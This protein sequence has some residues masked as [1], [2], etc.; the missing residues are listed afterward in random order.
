MWQQQASL[1]Q[2]I[3]QVQ[4]TPVSEMWPAVEAPHKSVVDMMR[5]VNLVHPKDGE[6]TI[7]GSPNPERL[8]DGVA[9]IGLKRNLFGFLKNPENGAPTILPADADPNL[10]ADPDN[11][12]DPHIDKN[13]NVMGQ[14][15]EQHNEAEAAKSRENLNVA[16]WVC[17]GGLAVV[18]YSYSSILQKVNA[19]H[20]LAS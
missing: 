1:W 11:I 14:Y 18:A 19:F 5:E 10:K 16:A 4:I 2:N 15:I 7:T 13:F 12:A 17:L 20:I 3:G 8:E 9:P 6:A